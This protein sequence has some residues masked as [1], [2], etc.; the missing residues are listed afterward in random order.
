M[1]VFAHVERAWPQPYWTNLRCGVLSAWFIGYD[2]ASVWRAKPHTDG[3]CTCLE[4]LDKAILNKP[5]VWGFE[6]CGLVVKVWHECD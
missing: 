3:V 6:A 4:G 2:S 1:T 5:E